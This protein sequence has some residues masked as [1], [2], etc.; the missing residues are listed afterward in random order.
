MQRKRSAVLPLT[1][2]YW[3]YSLK[4][5]RKADVRHQ[6]RTKETLECS[7]SHVSPVVWVFREREMLLNR[8]PS[9]ENMKSSAHTSR[10]S[11]GSHVI[12]AV[13]PGPAHAFPERCKL[14]QGP[15]PGHLKDRVWKDTVIQWELPCPREETLLCGCV[16]SHRR[17]TDD[18][19]S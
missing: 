5:G 12:L 19:Q 7:F 4:E 14:A 2:E 11:L 3:T 10:S 13:F 9:N 16:T 6:T 17:C 15:W 1:P 8:N 18:N